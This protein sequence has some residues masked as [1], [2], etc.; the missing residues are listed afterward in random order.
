MSISGVS[1]LAAV[2]LAQQARNQVAAGQ[3]G[4]TAEAAPTQQAG[5]GHHHHHGGGG[6]PLATAAAQPGA[7][8]ATG[9]N[10]VA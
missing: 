10:T 7:A 4:T 1:G 2:S 8:G 3:T 6:A 9:L 5:G